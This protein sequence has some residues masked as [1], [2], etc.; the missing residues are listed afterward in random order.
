MNILVNIFKSEG[1]KTLQAE[2]G[3]AGL[4]LMLSKRPDLVCLDIVLPRLSGYEVCQAARKTPELSSMPILMITSLDKKDDVVKGLKSGATDYITKPFSPIEVIARARVNLEQKFFLDR[5]TDRSKKFRLAYEVLETT[6]SSLDIKQVLFILVAR[7][8]N[9]LN[10]ERCSIIAVEGKWGEDKE[11]LKGRVL[12][13]H[14]DP[15]LAEI[16]LDLT[17]YPEIIKS[18]RT[19]E[20]VLIEDIETDPIMEGVREKMSHLGLKSIIAVPLTFRGEIMGALLLRSARSGKSF[21]DE[22]IAIARVIAG[23]SSNA[24]KNATLYRMLERKTDKL[25]RLNEELLRINEELQYLNTIKSDFVA[26]VSHE[27]RTPLTS[28]I[29]FSELLSEEHVGKLTEEQ[30]DYTGQICRKGKD[31]LN[32]INDILD[33]GRLEEGKIAFRFKPVDFREIINDVIFSTR[34]VTSVEPDIQTDIP[35]GLPQIEADRDKLLQIMNN[36]VSNALKYSDPGSPVKIDVKKISGRRETDHSDLMQV[37]V[38][39]KGIGIPDECHQKV[40]EQFFQV[41]QGTARP[42][43]GAGLGLFIAK[44]MVELHGGKIWFDSVPDKGTTFHFTIPMKQN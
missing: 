11:I 38:I 22:E 30:K 34:H 20:L 8:A 7:T 43:H 39:D 24:I 37:S 18:F 2:D 36:I 44:S 4:D 28:I 12:V 16:P 10:A 41:D 42:Y 6:T 9:A 13:S 19:G 35:E 25:A 3:H 33:T 5:L 15:N 27:L 31:L 32:L 23:A 17:K 14:D 40:F 1:Y 29:G 21:N 26:T